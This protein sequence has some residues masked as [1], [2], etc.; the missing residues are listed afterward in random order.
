MR[1]K[2][3][4][5]GVEFSP[6]LQDQIDQHIGDIVEFS[7]DNCKIIVTV[8]QVTKLNHTFEVKMQLT[9]PKTNI[10]AS[11]QSKQIMQALS[12]TKRK[13]LSQFK[14]HRKKSILNRRRDKHK[15]NQEVRF[16]EVA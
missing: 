16:K 15:H 2:I 10:F 7:P 8:E 11:S 9:G 5:N 4:L 14:T 6:L 1:R 13:V 12:E 3:N